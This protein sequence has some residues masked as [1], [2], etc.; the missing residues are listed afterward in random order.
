MAAALGAAGCDPVVAVGGPDERGR[1]VGL[2]VVA[3][4]WPGEGPLGAII[5]ALDHAAARGCGAVAVAACDLPWLDS[6]VLDA[7]ITRY[8]SATPP[9]DVVVA[10]AERVEPLCAVWACSAAPVLRE[11]FDDGERAV[12]RAITALRV[13]VVDVD[14][15]SVVNVN[16]AD[17]LAAVRRRADPATG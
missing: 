16:T 13:V 3:D 5:T 9:A 12:H 17:D 15:R 14:A 4:R 1:G 10:R 11:R 2:S 8:R 7:L 6:A